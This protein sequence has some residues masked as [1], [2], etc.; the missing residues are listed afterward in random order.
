M[1]RRSRRFH[2][3]TCRRARRN[4]I[5]HRFR[6]LASPSH[7]QITPRLIDPDNLFPF[8]RRVRVPKEAKYRVT[9]GET[10]TVPKVPNAGTLMIPR[11][12][13]YL[14]CDSVLTGS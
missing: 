2:A 9:H 12:V 6:D 13:C 11:Y 7:P 14:F 3:L 8:L 4:E 5:L 10:G 1:H